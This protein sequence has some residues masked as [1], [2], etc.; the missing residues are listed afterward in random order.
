MSKTRK[1]R[2]LIADDNATN[3]ELLEVYLANIDC[4]LAVAVDGRGTIGE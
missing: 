1:S 2:I 3:V 4:E